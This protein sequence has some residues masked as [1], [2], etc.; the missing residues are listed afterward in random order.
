[1]FY[2]EWAVVVEIERH[3]GLARRLHEAERVRCPNG[4]FGRRRIRL[5]L[6]KGKCELCGRTGNAEVH[7]VRTL[8]DG[9][10]LRQQPPGHPGDRRRLRLGCFG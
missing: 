10:A 4:Q 3:P 2:R 8:A 1:M 7:Q 6:R 5:R 9:C